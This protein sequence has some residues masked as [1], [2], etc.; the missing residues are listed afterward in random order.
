MICNAGVQFFVQH[1]VSTYISSSGLLK[2]EMIRHGFN[3][4]PKRPDLITC[5]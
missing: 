3:V 2:N 5:I 1:D 4:D